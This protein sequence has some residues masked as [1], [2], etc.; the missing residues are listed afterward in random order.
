MSVA[1]AAAAPLR[2]LQVTSSTACPFSQ[3]ERQLLVVAAS[4]GRRRPLPP[5]AATVDRALPRVAAV[6][7][8]SR[9]LPPVAAAGRQARPHR[10]LPSQPVAAAGRNC[11]SLLRGAVAAH[12]RRPPQTIAALPWR[13]RRRQHLPTSGATAA[14]CH[15]HPAASQQPMLPVVAPPLLLPPTPVSAQDLP[16]LVPLVG[17]QELSPLPQPSSIA[18]PPPPPHVSATNV[19]YATGRTRSLCKG[20]PRVPTY[21][22]DAPWLSARTRRFAVRHHQKRR[23]GRRTR[24]FY[25]SREALSRTPQRLCVFRHSVE[26]QPELLMSAAK[27][28]NMGV[29]TE[30][31]GMKA[32]VDC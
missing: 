22:G 11:R 13:C 26:F 25:S 8:Y 21:T 17:G 1:P 2:S 9:P 14:A 20:V 15:C 27:R 3:T 29:R 10:S 32:A 30:S 28:S 16:P 5:S 7:R 12:C 19:V 24:G 31:V 4:F 18:P 23:P 6:G